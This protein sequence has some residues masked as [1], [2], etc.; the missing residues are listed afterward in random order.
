MS[1]IKRKNDMAKW[2]FKGM[3]N[4]LQNYQCSQC[5]Y[6]KEVMHPSGKSK[7]KMKNGN[8]MK[9]HCPSCRE[10][11]HYEVCDKDLKAFM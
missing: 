7:R 10:E 11:I 4:G 8:S 6:M 5:G 3:N 1:P 2:I 9:F